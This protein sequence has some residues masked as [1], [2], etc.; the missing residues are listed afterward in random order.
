[1]QIYFKRSALKGAIALLLPLVWQVTYAQDATVFPELVFMDIAGAPRLTAPQLIMGV[2]KPVM[3]EG[4]GWASPAFYDVDKDG[5]KDLLIGEFNSM[6][7]KEIPVAVG[8]YLRVYKNIGTAERPAFSDTY[9]YLMPGRAYQN[10]TP[11]SIFTWCCMGFTP[12]IIDLDNDGYDDILTGQYDPGLINWFRGSEEGFMHGQH[13]PQ[14]GDNMLGR[15]PS[16]HKVSWD[17]PENWFYWQYSS[18]AFGDLDGDGLADMVTGG[19]TLRISKNIGKKHVP[20]FGRRQLLLDT[21]GRPLTV[22]N[23]TG[24]VKDN[25]AGRPYGGDAMI[26]CIVDWD[27]DGQLDLLVSDMHLEGGSVAVTFFKG[28]KTKEGIRF[29]PGVP[30]FKA[31]NGEKSF[32]GSWMHVN[33][34]DWNNDGI[35]DLIIG[36]SVATRA[37][38]FDHDLSWTWEWDTQIYKSNPGLMSKR[39][40][41]NRARD[42]ASAAQ[43]LDAIAATKKINSEDLQTIYDLRSLL[44]HT[45]DTNERQK[46]E[47]ELHLFQTK[48]KLTDDD[49]AQINK[50]H[51]NKANN[52]KPKYEDLVHQGYI[53]VLLGKEKGNG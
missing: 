19:S 10:G 23:G 50:H 8:S 11:L 43:Q 49:I 21:S 9:T 36:T 1:M 22:S 46:A 5:R 40:K 33:V 32:P 26:P 42:Y 27:N 18:A 38:I 4:N 30:L 20:E 51:I 6:G 3:G 53:Y 28:I 17:D 12:R 16:S 31:K 52:K 7:E 2:D 41:E 29:E 34:A 48:Y 24:K 15:R 44:G 37:G 13:V 45:K 25:Q 47:R 35:N 14:F 39:V